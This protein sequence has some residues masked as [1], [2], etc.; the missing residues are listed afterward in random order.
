[1]KPPTLFRLIN[2][3]LLPLVLGSTITTPAAAFVH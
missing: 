1:M 3:A 2:P